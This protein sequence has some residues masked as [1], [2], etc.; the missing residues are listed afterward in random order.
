[1]P[2]APPR[3]P[4]EDPNRDLGFGSVVASESRQR[5]L[6][7]DGSFNVRRE[8][9]GWRAALSLYHTLLTLS[10]P[11]FLALAAALYA[12]INALFALA[13]LACGATALA[14]AAATG[15]AARFAE[16]FFFSVQTLS[17]VGYGHMV[18]VGLA[19]NLV[20]AAESFVGL[21]TVALATGLAFARFSRPHARIV[22]SERA[23]IAPYRGITA[24]EFRIANRRR[25]QLNE[26]SAKVVFARFDSGPA[27]R[28]RHFDDLAL[29]RSRVAFFPLSWTLVHPIDERSPLFGLTREDLLASDAEFLILLTGVDETFSQTVHARSSYHAE[30][31]V[32][33]AR[34]ADIF[35]RGEAGGPLSIDV[36]R[37]H[38]LVEAG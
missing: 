3:P 18:P 38:E 36:G 27:A 17:T 8:G 13:Y 31:V 26:L 6:N 24:F 34:F 10:W 21:L 30:E 1:M 20:M 23:V 33:N 2:Q 15:A 4:V 29:E 25:T 19:A 9:L 28:R 35:D 7:R 14:G 32:W 12:V 37:I 22:F 5:L 11:R 16:A